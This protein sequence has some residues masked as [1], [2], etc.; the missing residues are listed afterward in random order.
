MCRHRSFDAS[1]V[2]KA[3]SQL[4]FLLITMTQSF[5]ALCSPEW[6]CSSKGGRGLARGLEEQ[7]S[8]APGLPRERVVLPAE[9]RPPGQ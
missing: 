1:W 8:G 6:W 9:P 4:T 2:V 3:E 7:F 5:C